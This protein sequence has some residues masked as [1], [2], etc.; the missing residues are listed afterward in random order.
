M[1]RQKVT[2]IIIFLTFIVIMFSMP[3][4]FIDA[5][6]DRDS[7]DLSQ[8]SPL[9]SQSPA[10]SPSPSQSPA[11]TSGPEHSPP[12][13][14]VDDPDPS[15]SYGSTVS[16][17][18]SAAGDVTLGGDSSWG[19]YQNFMNEFIANDRDF[20][21]PF[22]NVQHIFAEDDLTIVNFEG[23]LTDETR[24]VEKKFNFRA[25]PVFAASLVSGNIDIVSL[26]NNHSHDFYEAGYRDTIEHLEAAGV[27]SFGNERNLIVEVK[28]IK[29]GFF[30]FLIWEDTTEHREN[31]I[32]AIEELKNEGASLIIA[33]HHWGQESHYK[34]NAIQRNLGRFTIDNGADLVLGAHPH[35]IQGIEEYNGKNIVYSLANF[36]FGGNRWPPDMDTFIFQQTFTFEN[37]VLMETNDTNL[38]PARVSSASSHNNYQPTPAEGNEAVRILKRIQEF[39]DELN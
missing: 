4:A 18:I 35:V 14:P 8:S 36:S 23:T 16:I 28:G 34:P 19:S 6:I 32:A 38:I 31:I 39:S 12:P 30:G 20:S 7:P 27:L 11:N 29:I 1:K 25:S 37:G 22:R 26:G 13:D 9:P 15:P 5:G 24:T 3:F 2:Y 33:Y 10:S 21:F 17:T